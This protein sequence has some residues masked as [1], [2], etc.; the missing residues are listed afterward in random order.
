MTGVGGRPEVII[1]GTNGDPDKEDWKVCTSCV[2]FCQ[3][4]VH[5]LLI[6]G[7]SV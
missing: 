4:F 2:C 6:G 7:H 3:I 5:H 1:E